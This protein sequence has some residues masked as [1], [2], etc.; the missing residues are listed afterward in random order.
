M[1]RHYTVVFFLSLLFLSFF[2]FFFLSFFLPVFGFAEQASSAAGCARPNIRITCL[3]NIYPFIPNFDIEKLGYTGVY[4]FFS[5]YITW[6]RFRNE[7]IISD[8]E[9]ATFVV[10]INIQQN[11]TCECI[12]HAAYQSFFAHGE[13]QSVLS[14]Y[15]AIQLI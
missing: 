2:L 13:V 3:C 6:T 12:S 14:G 9:S 1:L 4:L 8:R 5:A 15:T 11:C 10:Y 7:M